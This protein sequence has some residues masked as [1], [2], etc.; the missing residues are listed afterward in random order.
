MLHFDKEILKESKNLSSIRVR[1]LISACVVSFLFLASILLFFITS[2]QIE[3][4]QDKIKQIF[5]PLNIH[6]NNL[7][8][9]LLKIE[10]ELS[11]YFYTKDK[12]AEENIALADKNVSDIWDRMIKID[13]DTINALIHKNEVNYLIRIEDK[14]YL[15]SIYRH[16]NDLSKK[17]QN[18]HKKAVQ[19]IEKNN[20]T[21]RLEKE[22]GSLGK[23]YI[24]FNPELNL[25]F[26]EN[27]LPNHKDLKQAISN[28][29][30]KIAVI[31]TASDDASQN[32]TFILKVI[33]VFIILLL[34][35]AVLIIVRWL[36]K[37]IHTN[38]SLILNYLK[39]LLRG[40][41]PNRIKSK[42]KEFGQVFST[43]NYLSHNITQVKRFA[44]RVSKNQFKNQLRMFETEG[45]FGQS[46]QNMQENLKKVS[47]E[48]EIRYWRNNGL[49]QISQILTKSNTNIQ[50]LSED[51]I[52]KLVKLLEINQA[53]FFT[54][55][56]ENEDKFLTL[57][58]SYAYN[59]KKFLDKKIILKKG[60]GGLLY[61][62]YL[63]K[64]KIYLHEIPK[65]YADITS[66][67]GKATPK[68]LLLMPLIDK[69]EVF[70]IIE[71]ASL[72]RITK[73]KIEFVE[74][75]AN[76]IGALIASIRKTDK[77]QTL[78]QDSQELTKTLKMQ[79]E[80]MRRNVSKL[81]E[82]QR[83]INQTQ[84]ELS[85]KEANMKAVINNTDHAILAFDKNYNITVA[86]RAMRNMYLEQGID[87]EAGKNLKDTLPTMDFEKHQKE[88]QRALSG[89][90]FILE[91][92]TKKY[93]QPAFYILHYNPI[94]NSEGLNIGASVFIENITQ[95]KIAEIRAQESETSLTALIND[96]EDSIIAI[97]N[98]YKITVLNEVAE[99]RFV[100]Q[101]FKTKIGDNILDKTALNAQNRWKQYYERV[102]AGERFVKIIKTGRYP[103]SIFHEYWFN[104]ITDENQ[105][106]IGASIFARD[107]TES[108]YNEI[109]IKKLL[110]DS[111]EDT[112]NMK[113]QKKVMQEEVEK[114]QQEITHLRQQIEKN[115]SDKTEKRI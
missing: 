40:K 68:S 1:F 52:I 111:V 94:K 49:A 7:E 100:S 28:M 63:E 37:Y 83:K 8:K 30:S 26:K 66:G 112:E 67:L 10:Q 51:L 36:K 60:N 31:E 89:E 21:Y 35:V 69:G 90:K 14:E 38:I 4:H 62:T 74:N 17:N 56:D 32:L 97:D 5:K 55:E 88:Y 27:I 85:Q 98:N 87:L 79:E 44:D 91:R 75:I 45:E 23:E 108:K 43:L 46:L 114:Y 103:D 105:K 115:Y 48:N 82:S 42:N 9:G 72:Q 33:Q 58:A 11:N 13:L 101:G 61:Q 113:A 110:L 106:I 95:R 15:A 54:V 77:T 65:N 47:S 64:D 92:A 76:N 53:G 29:I 104:P 102:L 39:E 25:F 70:G 84:K 12:N 20:V 86:N 96:T 99:K 73:Y 78:L 107:I 18:L 34:F 16:I 81:Q 19:L 93:G 109:E 2:S 3:K 59:K 50:Q 71:F 57:R 80:R 22:K 41:I 24:Y 6:T